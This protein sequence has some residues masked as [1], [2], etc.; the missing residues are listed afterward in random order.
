MAHALE[1]PREDPD[2]TVRVHA[3][4]AATQTMTL[5]PPARAR[6]KPPRP[7]R[8]LRLSRRVL[9]I[10]AL[11]AALVVVVA[12]AVVSLSGGDAKSPIVRTGGSHVTPSTAAPTGVQLPPE[13]ERDLDQLEESIR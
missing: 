5:P 9:V 4:R 1:A 8:S 10:G 11:A 7:A 6:A 12:L 3:P 2:A 13:L